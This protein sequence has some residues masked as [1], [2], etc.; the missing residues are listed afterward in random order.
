MQGQQ[1]GKRRKATAETTR[2][3]L[4]DLPND[5]KRMVN[6][7]GRLIG[8]L[9]ASPPAK[10]GLHLHMTAMRARNTIEECY[11][12]LPEG[13]GMEAR[14]DKREACVEIGSQ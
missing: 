1:S 9:H 10:H 4:E 5:T 14:L 3:L 8:C 7:A 12:Y 6:L 13:P 2:F 11:R